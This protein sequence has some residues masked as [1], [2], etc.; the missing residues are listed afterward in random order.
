[1]E[2]SKTV[3]DLLFPSAVL[4]MGRVGQKNCLKNLCCRQSDGSL[5]FKPPLMQ[6]FGFKTIY[7]IQKREEGKEI[8]LTKYLCNDNLEVTCII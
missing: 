2:F 6:N 8:L 3:P 4:K 1:M 7:T 5:H